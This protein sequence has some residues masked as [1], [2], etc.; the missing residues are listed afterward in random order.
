MRFLLPLLSAGIL[1]GSLEACYG[2]TEIELQIDTDVP[3]TTVRTS[4]ITIAASPSAGALATATT[5]TESNTC[6]DGPAGGRNKIGTLVLVPESGT[7]DVAIRVVLGVGRLTRDC[8]NGSYESCIVADRSLSYRKHESLK[9]PIRL[10]NA[11]SAKQCPTGQ[12]CSDGECI[13]SIVACAGNSCTSTVPDAGDEP[14]DGGL[15]PF[16]DAGRRDAGA[17][18]C[19][20]CPRCASATPVCCLRRGQVSCETAVSCL[21]TGNAKRCN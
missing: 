13:S 12:T 18:T 14:D 8:A 11:C 4:G 21:A 19:N 9:V 1:L 7:P 17:S 20:D 16:V 3:C 15:F 6:T 2:A 10:D 5:V